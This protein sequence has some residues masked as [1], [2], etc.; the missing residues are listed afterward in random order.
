MKALSATAIAVS[1]A[2][3]A[4]APAHC[5]GPEV[6]SRCLSSQVNTT[7]TSSTGTTVRCLADE[8]Q[9]YIWMIN[10]GKTQDPW[11]AD[12]M[13]WAACHQQGH[14]DAQCRAILD[15]T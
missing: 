2:I 13:A 6:G 15:G 11:I 7:T 9:G 3:G 1:I 14:T 5:D 8:Q 4:A 12:Q 10:T